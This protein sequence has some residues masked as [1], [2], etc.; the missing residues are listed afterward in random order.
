MGTVLQRNLVVPDLRYP[1]YFDPATNL[2]PNNPAIIDLR[3]Y[4][5][6]DANDLRWSFLLNESNLEVQLAPTDNVRKFAHFEEGLI[7]SWQELWLSYL[8][9]VTPGDLP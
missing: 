8:N 3:R 1:H 6:V 2:M 7:R 5:T 4:N 9:L